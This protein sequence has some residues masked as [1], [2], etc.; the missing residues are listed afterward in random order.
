MLSNQQKS[1][2]TSYA[3]IC[4]STGLL[5]FI[6]NLLQI[7][8]IIRDRKQR[9][10]IFGIILLSLSIADIFISIAQLYRGIIYCLALSL[11]LDLELTSRL[12][13]PAH[14]AVI[15]CLTSSFCHVVFIAIIRVLALVFPLRMNR[16]ITKSRCRFIVACLWVLSVG[17]IFL[18]Y[19]TI[20]NKLGGYLA[21][22]TS[23]ILLVAY[24]VICYRMYNRRHVQSNDLARRNRQQSDKDVVLYSMVLTFFFCLCLLPRSISYLV[25]GPY[26]ARYITA[27]MYTINPFFDTLLYFFAS[28]Y[29]RRRRENISQ[30]NRVNSAGTNTKTGISETALDE[31]SRV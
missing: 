21:I 26:F 14:V 6:A 1:R 16:I 28:H 3:G 27:F 29:K 30:S 15:F 10:S 5:G 24:S 25:E 8:F 19:F 9:N 18:S 22:I 4:I 12:D 2:L 31:T 7:I 17:L 20:G 23:G 13:R 11:V